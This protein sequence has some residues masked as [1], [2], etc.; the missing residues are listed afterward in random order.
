MFIALA[1]GRLSKNLELVDEDIVASGVANVIIDE[2]F[3]MFEEI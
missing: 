2:L 1:P 3:V